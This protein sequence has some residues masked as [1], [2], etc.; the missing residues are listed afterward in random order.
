MTAPKLFNLAQMTTTTT[1]TGPVTLIAATTGYR[2]F[3]AAGVVNG[4]VVRYSISTGTATE[5]GT[6]VV[7]IT[8]PTTSMSRVF[9]GST[10]GVPIVLSGTSIV[11]LTPVAEDFLTVATPFYDTIA[12]VVAA[13]IPTDVMC[14]R[15]NG[16]YA[17]GDDGAATYIRVGAAPAHIGWVRSRDGAYWEIVQAGMDAL[18]ICQFGAIGDG[19][20]A[21]ATTNT[22]AIKG[23]DDWILAHDPTGMYGG[24][25][26]VPEGDFR[27]NPSV[28]ALHR[29]RT[30]RGRGQRISLLQGIGTGVFLNYA[31]AACRIEDLGLQFSGATSDTAIDVAAGMDLVISRC[32]LQDYYIAFR[33]LGTVII[34]DSFV[35]NGAFNVPSA[36]GRAAQVLGGTFKLFSTSL[37]TSATVLPHPSIEIRACNQVYITDTSSANFSEGLLIDPL[38]GETVLDVQVEASTFGNNSAHAAHINA[39]GTVRRVLITGSGLNDT[40]GGDGV[41]VEGTGTINEVRVNGNSIRGNVGSGVRCTRANA[42]MIND[43][44]IAANTSDGI[45][46][47][48]GPN[49]TGFIISGN[50]IGAFDGATGNGAWGIY[51]SAFACDYYTVGPNVFKSNTNGDIFDGGTGTHKWTDYEY[52]FD[53]VAAA[54]A[55]H[56]V[57]AVNEIQ[58]FG[59]TTAGDGG[60]ASYKRVAVAPSH[61]GAIHSADGTWWEIAEPQ[62]RPQMFGAIGN[63]VALDHVA[64]NNMLE[65]AFQ[66]GGVDCW[67]DPATYAT[68]A[69]IIIKRGVYFRAN[70]GYVI[71]RLANASNCSIAE[72]YLF[73]TLYTTG[74]YD[75]TDN[76]NYTQNYGFEGIIFDG[77]WSGQSTLTLLY[78]VKMYGRQL[79]FVNCSIDNVAGVGF[80]SAGKG[81]PGAHPYNNTESA[82]PSL[83]DGLDITNCLDEHWINEGPPDT[84]KGTITTNYCGDPANIG[85]VPQVSR[86]FPGQPVNSVVWAM[87]GTFQYMNLNNAKFGYGLY[88]YASHRIYGDK[89]VIYGSWGGF[90]SEANA[91]GAISSVLVQAIN[92]SWLADAR[93]Y[94]TTLSDDIMFPDVTIRRVTGND[95]G[96]IGVLDSG[97]AQWGSIRN[98]QATV[99]GG[100]FVKLTAPGTNISAMDAK[101][102]AVAL[103]T[104]VGCSR[105]NVHC[106]FS[107]VGTVWL[108]DQ[109]YIEG[110]F[111]FTGAVGTG[112]TFSSGVITTPF[113]APQCLA[114]STFAY[115]DEL[116]VHQRALSVYNHGLT[117][118]ATT[119]LYGQ[120]NGPNVTI[121]GATTISSF[122]VAPEGVLVNVRFSSAGGGPPLL[123]NSTALQCPTGHDTQTAQGDTM[124][125]LSLGAGNWKILWYQRAGVLP[126]S[127]GGTGA[128]T[129]VTAANALNVPYVLASSGVGVPLTGTLVETTLATITIP[130]GAMGANGWFTVE[131][132]WSMTNSV[133]NKVMK[134]AL[135]AVAIHTE[136]ST[137]QLS[138]RNN[139][140]TTNR[141]SA[142]SQICSS[143]ISAGYGITANPL[144]SHTVNTAVAQDITLTGTLANIADT[145]T[146]EDYTVTV[147]YKA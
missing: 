3:V 56:V 125:A 115:I 78:G 17:A 137:T 20:N 117:A 131:S 67:S 84:P 80:W 2:T 83:I 113:A 42:L 6:G 12:A 102:C 147:Y 36:S 96:G 69:P 92:R 9:G 109:A 28:I 127:E 95:N 44:T 99:A 62:L 8:G 23:V 134:V 75:I 10:T 60:A 133:N 33:S 136:T 103:H 138:W 61:S 143:N 18:N 105:V 68:A 146:L 64:I 100:T 135:A 141:N 59:Y 19:N 118:A 77:N 48:G 46:I 14:I 57:N 129:A 140:K 114:D 81:S 15:T 29:A 101:G 128:S 31:A 110:V 76:A 38:L 47:T 88:I 111:S 1:G 87:S 70:H 25:I 91:Y 93:P 89:L 16:Y 112:N 86:H 63:G 82:M 34:E 107:G 26:G 40:T 32:N 145:I 124:G 98:R 37:N 51:I 74:A 55:Y 106:N 97:G 108:N 7:S 5:Y 120:L 13:M 35:Y 85:T 130:A 27:F 50:A 94:L 79:R 11:S 21:N 139:T 71:I 58:V 73:T 30:L 119:P 66:Q 39:A 144:T 132:A 41:L 122:D 52:Q 45:S 90:Y 142:A 43:N 54:T 4:D 49:V 121:T 123:T 72:S 126:L 104:A 116:G 53:N 65:T 22:N 24:D